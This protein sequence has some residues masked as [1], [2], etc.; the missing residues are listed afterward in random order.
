MLDPIGNSRVRLEDGATLCTCSV[1]RRIAVH[2]NV[3]GVRIFLLEIFHHMR[4]PI[5]FQSVIVSMEFFLF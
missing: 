2:D 1:G 5:F 3:R 4:R